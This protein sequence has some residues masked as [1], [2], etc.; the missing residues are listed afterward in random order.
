MRINTRE[1]I[2]LSVLLAALILLVLAYSPLSNR[3]GDGSAA[4][5]PA[6]VDSLVQQVKR[7]EAADSTPNKSVKSRRRSQR[8]D[9]AGGNRRM[10]TPASRRHLEEII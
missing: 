9:S 7:L 3:H 8:A 4:T 6:L 10:V 2:A 1:T 5:D